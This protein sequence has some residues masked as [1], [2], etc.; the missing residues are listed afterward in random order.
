[1]PKD[2]HGRGWILV[3]VLRQLGELL[4]L[5]LQQLVLSK[6]LLVIAIALIAAGT[7]LLLRLLTCGLLL[8]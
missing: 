3:L 2:L 4:N 7:A 8:L 6:E 1:M 5:H